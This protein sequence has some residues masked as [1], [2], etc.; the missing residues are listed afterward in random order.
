MRRRLAAG[1]APDLQVPGVEIGILLQRRETEE[2]VFLISKREKR[3]PNIVY[4]K[5]GDRTILHNLRGCNR[6]VSRT[7]VLEHSFTLS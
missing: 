5:F 6:L 7:Y 4:L 1:P 2:N 3:K